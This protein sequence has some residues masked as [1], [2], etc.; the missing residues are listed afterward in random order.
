MTSHSTR[1]TPR[2]GHAAQANAQKTG[3]LLLGQRPA[4]QVFGHGGGG[5]MGLHERVEQEAGLGGVALPCLGEGASFIGQRVSPASRF[6]QPDLGQEAHALAHRVH[7]LAG[8]RC[9]G[10]A[11]DLLAVG[12]ELGESEDELDLLGG[13]R[14]AAG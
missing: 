2:I 14:P 7:A 10:R 3:Q 1:Y 6:G 4:G 9:H 8:A 13:T 11:P 12:A 5:P